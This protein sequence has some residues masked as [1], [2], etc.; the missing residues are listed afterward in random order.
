MLTKQFPDS[1][2]FIRNIEN[3]S[4][5]QVLHLN[6]I[7]FNANNL[8]QS[9]RAFSALKT[10]YFQS[11]KFEGTITVQEI[12]NHSNLEELIMDYSSLDKKFL[13]GISG[14]TSLEVLSLFS[15]DLNG[16]LPVQEVDVSGNELEGILPLCMGNLTSLRLIDLS[17]NRFTGDIASSSLTALTLLEYLSFLDNSFQIPVSFSSFVNFSNLKNDLRVLD[18]SHDYL[19]GKFPSW[20]LQN[21]TKLKDLNLRDKNFTGPFQLRS[22]PN[23]EILRLDLSKKDIPDPTNMTSVFPNLRILNLSR[24][25]FEGNIPSYFHDMKFLWAL[26]LSNNNMSGEIPE[27][28]AVGC[29]SLIFLKLSN[30]KFEGQIFPQV[31]N[32]P[33]LECLYLDGNR[34][35]GGIPDS[36]SNISLLVL[37]LTSNNMSGKLPRWI[38]NMS[39]TK[40]IAISNNNLQS[41]ILVEFCKLDNLLFLNLSENNLTGSIPSCFNPSNIKHVHLFK[42]RLTGPITRAFYKS[43]SLVTLDLRDNYLS[44]S[45]PKWIGTL[46]EP[47]ILLLRAN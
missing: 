13:Q 44:G 29:L 42:N 18:L 32:L 28:L 47:S 8:L 17:S 12:Y 5:L 24:N 38:G 1:L 11:S 3:L 37:D 19:Q 15:C 7:A 16:T 46:L 43:T 31:V 6:S 20:L 4:P 36:L 2:F 33:K 9:L 26:D 27:H 35:S 34:F 39:S 40:E 41:S 14:M 21:N 10:L 30:N 45:I 22:R 25:I 23:P